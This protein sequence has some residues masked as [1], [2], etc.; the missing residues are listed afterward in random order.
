[1][2]ACQEMLDQTV[3]DLDQE[4]FSELTES[5]VQPL[6]VQMVPP[7]VRQTTQSTREL[8]QKTFKKHLYQLS[9]MERSSHKTETQGSIL[10]MNFGLPCFT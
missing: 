3:N 5:L 4:L 7:F 8:A 9:Q 2:I 1:M 10:V 6:L